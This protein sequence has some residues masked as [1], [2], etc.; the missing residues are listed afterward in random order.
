M[1]VALRLKNPVLNHHTCKG[2][3]LVFHVANLRNEYINTHGGLIIKE[4]ASIHKKPPSS[5]DRSQEI[6][7]TTT[8]NTQIFRKDWEGIIWKQVLWRKQMQNR[9]S[10]GLGVWIGTSRFGFGF[11]YV[12]NQLWAK[13]SLCS[14]CTFPHFQNGGKEKK[15]LSYISGSP[16]VQWTSN[17]SIPWE[18]IKMHILRPNPRPSESETLGAGPGHLCSN[19]PSRGFWRTLKFENH[20]AKWMIDLK[21]SLKKKTLALHWAS[22]KLH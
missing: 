19:K 20:Q 6:R 12:T 1:S 4:K 8:K 10:S 5:K 3:S 14:Y 16:C 22:V 2:L 13:K 15:G 21:E 9:K 18:L 7:L 17:I 11:G